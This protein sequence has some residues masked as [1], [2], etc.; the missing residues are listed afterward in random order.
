MDYQW[1]FSAIIAY[2]A[3]LLVG[4]QNTVILGVT[5]LVL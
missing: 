4:L 1:D 3:L 2:K 5:C